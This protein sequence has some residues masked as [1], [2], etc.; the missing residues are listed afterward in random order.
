MA[1]NS[2]LPATGDV[3]A[4]DD[5]GGGVKVQRA[6]VTWGPDGTMN[7]ADVA[8]GKPMPVQLRS[9]TGLIPIGEPTDA[10]NTATDTTSVTAVSIWKQISASIQV[11]AGIV[12]SAKAAIKV[13]SGDIAAGAIAAG[14]TSIADNEDVASA[15][16]D[17]G[18]KVLFKRTDTPA[19]SS[20]T[21]GDYEQPQISGGK[22]WTAPLGFFA[23]CSTDITRPNDTTP[24]SNGD[25]WSDST[26]APTS[27]G[28]TFTGAGRKS[29][30]SGI[31]LDLWV[32]SSNN[33]G[34]M[35]G[36]V[37]IFDTSV[38]NIND[39]SAF[40]I[41]DAEIKTVVAKVPFTTVADTNNAGVHVQ[42]LQIGYTCVGSANLR[43]LVK[44]K[45][46][47]TPAAQE[48]LSVRIKCLQID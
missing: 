23:S 8:T 11:L 6:K 35:Q 48:V 19:N 21:D 14:A 3:I 26:S 43:F 10:A 32:S 4:A 17:R 27:G 39:N 45:A 36:E 37:W 15:D 12:G 40:A 38:T 20:G 22:V 41:S 5:V 30:G 7:D 1:D 25:N 47:Y 42:N 24:Y 46:A 16:G 33:A 28:F 31:I 18:I 2:T 44:L 13:A 29:G 34:A 9:A